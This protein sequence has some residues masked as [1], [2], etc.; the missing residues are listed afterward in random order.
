M[1]IISSNA[2]C[3]LCQNE[4]AQIKVV[5]CSWNWLNP[6]ILTV[7]LF[8]QSK[9]KNF[10]VLLLYRLIVWLIETSLKSL[11]LPQGCYF[12]DWEWQSAAAD[13]SG[14]TPCFPFETSHQWRPR[15][16]APGAQGPGQCERDEYTQI[17]SI[18]I[19]I[20]CYYHFT[21]ASPCCSRSPGSSSRKRILTTAWP[22]LCPAPPPSWHHNTR[23]HP[24]P[25]SSLKT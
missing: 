4:H 5:D 24:S 9:K 13:P 17:Y 12:R 23:Q 6:A 19:L 2:L 7:V 10:T 21:A 18:R 8:F 3:L 22:S 20:K 14:S 11:L 25:R 15:E 16:W 1:P